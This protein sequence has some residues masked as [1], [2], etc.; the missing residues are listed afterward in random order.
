[1]NV[2]CPAD[3]V[4]IGRPLR[5]DWGDRLTE[6]ITNNPKDRVHSID[7]DLADRRV[8]DAIGAALR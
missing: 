1:V 2:W 7:E 3:A 6:V 4:A 8:A 5:G